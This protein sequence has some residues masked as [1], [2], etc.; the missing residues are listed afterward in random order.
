[1]KWL[2]FEV[3]KFEGGVGSTAAVPVPLFTHQAALL[4]P[5]PF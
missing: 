2:L 3:V 4:L 5:L 1:M